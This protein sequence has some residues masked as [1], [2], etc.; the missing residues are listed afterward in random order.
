MIFGTAA[1]GEDLYTWEDKEGNLNVTEERP[2][3]G[4]TVL[5]IDQVNIK[6][7][8]EMHQEKL[9]LREAMARERAS[10]NWA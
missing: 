3:L 6:S 2:P 7:A 4:I 1:W 8:D 9:R 10:F 5:A